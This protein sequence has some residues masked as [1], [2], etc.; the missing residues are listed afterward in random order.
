MEA[1]APECQRICGSPPRRNYP[2]R[3]K[4]DPH[5]RR[6]GTPPEARYRR[7]RH[8][9][10]RCQAHA[11][12][13]DFFGRKRG[14][15]GYGGVDYAH[16]D[17]HTRAGCQGE[18]GHETDFWT[19]GSCDRSCLLLAQHFSRLPN[20]GGGGDGV[21]SIG[22]SPWSRPPAPAALPV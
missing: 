16:G 22:A 20:G 6:H 21:V 15:I 7:R 18:A 17:T 8:D 11:S 3:R 10:H 2:D 19:S 4:G 14:S 9:G 13:K 1:Y 5:H 12:Q